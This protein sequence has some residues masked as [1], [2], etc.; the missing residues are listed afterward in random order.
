MTDTMQVRAPHTGQLVR[1]IPADDIGSVNQ[2]VE[3]ARAAQAEWNPTP[4]E[5]AQVLLQLADRIDAASDLIAR[6][7]V[8]CTGKLQHQVEQIE[9]PHVTD[10]LRFFAGAARTQPG[11]PSGRYL[12]GHHSHVDHTPVGVVAAILPWNYPLMMLAWKLGPA[13]ACGNTI[14]AKPAPNTSLSALLVARILRQISTL[15]LLTIVNGG[16]ATG[17]ALA[18]SAANL[19]CFTG[20]IRTG[21]TVAETAGSN[22]TPT[23][24]ELGGNCPVLLLPDLR[25]AEL[26]DALQRIADSALF[27]AGQSCAAPSRLI[28]IGDRHRHDRIRDELTVILS[29]PRPGQPDDP[30]AAYGSLAGSEQ[31]GRLGRIIRSSEGLC[32][33][34]WRSERNHVHPLLLADVQPGDPAYDEELFGP[35]LT[36]TRAPTAEAALRLAEHGGWGLAC[37]MWGNDHRLLSLLADR[38][39]FG[40]VWINTHLAQTP[41][42]PHGGHNASGHGSDLSLHA[43]GAYRRVRTV[44]SRLA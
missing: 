15:P 19:I 13:L 33:L 20:S 32:C 23:H 40:E 41:E 27:N 28:V 3:Q 16:A 44:T 29:H 26:T 4:A 37:S 9:I 12:R 8:A 10:T 18:A 21:R 11:V 31:T 35:A 5:R 39:P 2:A 1:E 25:D 17:H 42:L 30:N 24:L 7:E 43:L 22:G 36:L 6:E 14:V 34:P 38:L